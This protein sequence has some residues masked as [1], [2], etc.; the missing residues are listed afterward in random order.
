[1]GDKNINVNFKDIYEDIENIQ[2]IL[3]GNLY[4]KVSVI[5]IT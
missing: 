3:K 5:C 4:E 2:I 1:M